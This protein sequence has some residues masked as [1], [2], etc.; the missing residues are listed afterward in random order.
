MI[1]TI[2][3]ALGVV[4]NAYIISNQFKRMTHELQGEFKD[5]MSGLDGLSEELKGMSEELKGM[6]AELKGMSEELTRTSRE[7][8]R[9]L[10]DTV[11]E[12]RI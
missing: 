4:G 7:R 3:A 1:P 9:E 6:S 11:Q 8:E 10:T 5:L 12:G 2:Y